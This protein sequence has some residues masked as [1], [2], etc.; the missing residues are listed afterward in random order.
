MEHNIEEDAQ[1][2]VIILILSLSMIEY[3]D[4]YREIVK[5]HIH[6]TPMFTYEVIPES[7]LVVKL[8]VMFIYILVRKLGLWYFKNEVV[9]RIH[10]KATQIYF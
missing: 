8:F 6:Y 7:I 5:Y 2:K 3:C 4:R 10:P 1:T 9:F